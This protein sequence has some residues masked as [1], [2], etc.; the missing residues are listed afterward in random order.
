MGFNKATLTLVAFL[1]YM[2]MSGLLTQIGILIS[3][4]ADDLN[5][6]IT[7][8]SSMFSLLTGGTFVG[9]FLAMWVYGRFPIKRIFQLNYLVFLLFLILLVS[10]D[11]RL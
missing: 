2:V 9:T 1:I 10:L 11:V 6:S 4:L 3:P 7:A 5:I 8:A